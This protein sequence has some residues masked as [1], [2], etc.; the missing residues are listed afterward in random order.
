MNTFKKW[1]IEVVVS[2]KTVSYEPAYH[3]VKAQNA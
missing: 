3:T 1:F 2:L